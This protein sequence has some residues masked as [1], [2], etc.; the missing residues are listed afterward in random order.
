MGKSCAHVYNKFKDALDN[1]TI[2]L[3]MI[4]EFAAKLEVS[5]QI[6][7]TPNSL[8]P[9]CVV[10]SSNPQQLTRGR[11]TER[12]QVRRRRA[13]LRR[14]AAPRRPPGP[15]LRRQGPGPE[16][17]RPRPGHRQGPRGKAGR[18]T[19][20]PQGLKVGS[21]WRAVEQVM[22]TGEKRI[23]CRNFMV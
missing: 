15:G 12:P 19:L 14:Q 22:G 6:T 2:D 9:K 4:D 7:Q 16:R 23:L 3:E 18:R 17:R 11:K 20:G 21:A 5:C 8:A 13:G 1:G 10:A